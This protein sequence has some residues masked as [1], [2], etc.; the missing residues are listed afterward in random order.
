VTEIE[1]FAGGQKLDVDF[2]AIEQELKKLWKDASQAAEG[3]STPAL[4]RACQM[5]L[6]VWC[7]GVEEVTHATSVVAKVA[8]VRPCRVV[9][10]VMD[11][12]P[13][14]GDRLEASITAHCAYTPGAGKGRQVCCE[15]ITLTGG[16]RGAEQ[17]RGAVLPL[18]LP[19][20][21][22]FLW[23]TGDPSLLDDG[24][25]HAGSELDEA[26]LRASDRVMV[27]SC[28]FDDPA[29]RFGQLLSLPAPL[30]DL[31]WERLR[32]WR[33]LTAGVFDAPAHETAPGRVERIHVEYA[34]PRMRA[35]SGAVLLAAWVASRLGWTDPVEGATPR[36]G[37][38]QG[39]VWRLSRPSGEPGGELELM[40]RGEKGAPGVS[41]MRL[42]TPDGAF[43]L[44][45]AGAPD[46]I[47]VT[48]SRGGA[49]VSSHVG[50]VVERDKATLLCRALEVGGADRIYGQSLRL[51][52]RLFG[53]H[54][55]EM[56]A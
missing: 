47:G 28:R 54:P 3:D 16:G 56:Q 33:E 43:E 53:H 22:V 18:L 39:R 29:V 30:S 20:L 41:M 35:K 10:A 2:S 52:A 9:M 37:R 11:R 1:S 32:G 8:N 50:R 40:W 49:V 7:D 51:A 17:V 36:G 14:R 48:V 13:A 5:N 55:K 46:A 15:Q 34:G 31:S 26:L 27:D 25:G 23:C 12:D 45:R 6:V 44:A 24:K 38:K 4:T 42:E 21:P 19:D